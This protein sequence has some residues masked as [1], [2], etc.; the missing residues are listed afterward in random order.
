M[1]I[2]R[3]SRRTCSSWPTS[4]TATPR[5]PG[6]RTTAAHRA[7]RRAP[8]HGRGPGAVLARRRPSVARRRARSLRRARAPPAGARHPPAPPGRRHRTTDAYPVG[9]PAA[10]RR[11]PAHLRRTDRDHGQPHGAAFIDAARSSWRP[12]AAGRSRRAHRRAVRHRAPRR[13]RRAARGPARRHHLRLAQ[14]RQHHAQRRRG[15]PRDRACAPRSSRAGPSASPRA[16]RVRAPWRP[17]SRSAAASLGYRTLALSASVLVL[18]EDLTEAR[19]REREL[20]SR[21]PPS[22]RST[23]A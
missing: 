10:L 12:C 7:R 19:R 23:T 5:S 9:A 2:S 1:T 14:R 8:G 16:R 22:A 3:T 18:V 6:S 21:K 15:G 11:D 17:S 13:R 20:R 4:V